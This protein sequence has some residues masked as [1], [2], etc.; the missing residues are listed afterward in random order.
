MKRRPTDRPMSIAETEGFFEPGRA[1][2]F[3]YPG[4]VPGTRYTPHHMYI[5]EALAKYPLINQ[6]NGI[7]SDGNCTVVYLE[8]NK[9]RIVPHIAP[10]VFVSFTD[11]H[12]KFSC[13]GFEISSVMTLD[14]WNDNRGK[15]LEKKLGM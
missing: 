9:W 5:K 1:M 2:K 3:L 4:E 13:Y 7:I 8:W 15:R 12:G 10:I 6:W 11:E 14:E